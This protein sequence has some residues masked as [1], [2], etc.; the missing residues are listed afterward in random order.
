MTGHV[1]I[2]VVGFVAYSYVHVYVLV[3]VYV[4]VYSV[5]KGQACRWYHR[6]YV[7]QTAT[8]KQR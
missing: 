6:R 3:H 4:H 7:M 5:L 8:N 2:W 1:Y